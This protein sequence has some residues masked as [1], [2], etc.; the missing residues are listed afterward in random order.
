MTSSGNAMMIEFRS[1]CATTAAGWIATWMADYDKPEYE[2]EFGEAA[3]FSPNPVKDNLFII[4]NPILDIDYI[5]VYDAAGRLID[6]IYITSKEMSINMRHYKSGLYLFAMYN[7]KKLIAT[8][9]VIRK[10]AQ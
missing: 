7:Q 4:I 1:D 2:F 5:L 8:E 6:N 3:K 9:K 10:E